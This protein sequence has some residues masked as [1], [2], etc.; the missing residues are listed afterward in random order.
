MLRHGS[1]RQCCLLCHRRVA[2][3]VDE[4]AEVS[5]AS[6][7]DEGDDDGADDGFEPDFIDDASQAA[8]SMD[9]SAPP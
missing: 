7:D 3:F 5:S 1:A 8:G 2:A 4:E 6:S 9:R